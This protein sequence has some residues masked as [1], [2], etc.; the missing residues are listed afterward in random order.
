MTGRGV[1]RLFLGI[2]FALIGG[3]A[4][5]TA[6]EPALTGNEQIG[7]LWNASGPIPPVQI[8]STLNSTNF[9]SLFPTPTV[10]KHVC[11]SGCDY[12]GNTG[13]QTAL[14]NVATDAPN[15]GEL[16]TVDNVN[17]GYS[18]TFTNPTSSPIVFSYN[19]PAHTEVLVETVTPN[20]IQPQGT[21]PT[22]ANISTYEPFEAQINISCTPPAGCKGVYPISVSDGAAGLILDGIECSVS[23]T[24][25]SGCLL[26]GS[27]TNC[28]AWQN[29]PAGD[30]GNTTAY[31]NHIWVMRSNFHGPPDYST[32]VHNWISDDSPFISVTDTLFDF[33]IETLSDGGSTF[34]ESHTFFD[35]FAPG[36]ISIINNTLFG[37]MTEQIFFGGS[38][39]FNQAV[40]PSDIE[41]FKNSIGND[42]NN[43]TCKTNGSIKNLF[44]LKKGVRARI[45][46]NEFKYSWGALANGGTQLGS[47]IDTNVASSVQG[48]GM[49]EN[50]NDYG[51]AVE[52]IDFESNDVQH[53]ARF[54]G[55]QGSSVDSEANQWT[56]TKRIRVSN[57]LVQDIGLGWSAFQDIGRPTSGCQSVTA[58]TTSGTNSLTFNI[59]NTTQF[60]NSDLI[61]ATGFIAPSLNF[62][63]YLA[64]ITS[65]VVNTSVTISFAD[66]GVVQSATTLGQI[67]VSQ[68]NANHTGVAFNPGAI[69]W[70][71]NPLGSGLAATAAVI[72]S[73][74][75]VPGFANTETL[76][77]STDPAT[78]TNMS[79]TGGFFVGC[80]IKTTGFTPS[81]FNVAFGGASGPVTSVSQVLNSPTNQISF[82]T[83]SAT[84]SASV[85]G[86]AFCQVPI[87]GPVYITIANNGLYGSLSPAGANVAESKFA[88]SGA[89]GANGETLFTLNAQIGVGG[90]TTANGIFPYYTISG[91]IEVG[92]QDSINTQ[93]GETILAIANLGGFGFQPTHNGSG[94]LCASN[95]VIVDPSGD[96]FNNWPTSGCASTPGTAITGATTSPTG[97]WTSTL[98]IANYIICATGD[99]NLGTMTSMVS[100]ELTGTFAAD[101]PNIPLIQ[102][103]MA[104]PNDTTY[105]GPRTSW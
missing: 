6:A 104:L 97:A 43:T 84:G 46:G 4:I 102:T 50:A 9:P 19:C 44:E 24:N 37:C 23:G 30:C 18:E 83:N 10:T 65:R 69:Y 75:P 20:S 101:G 91:N 61:I 36:P 87:P 49:S 21:K 51:A 85:E 40:N 80:N 105:W 33:G 14:A 78:P 82:P 73:G 79:Q 45:A 54:Y 39:S 53:I 74:S 72:T 12:N 68:S 66:G 71:P 41:V 34:T 94:T 93:G 28:P 8:A 26:A 32:L 90:G 5:S 86:A 11:A 98:G 47:G 103:L 7:G 15:C 25:V 42:F 59:A 56:I 52:D 27:G 88:I 29:I 92:D 67:C 55:I 100:C 63:V 58:A 31:A 22:R 60:G 35:S 89:G 13:L 70:T 95:N 17:N 1:M 96:F 76:T 64:S 38:L 16:I 77:F 2:A 57:N 99:L 62:N 81:T 48:S 3:F